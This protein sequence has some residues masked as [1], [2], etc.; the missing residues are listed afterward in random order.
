LEWKNST[1]GVS[2]HLTHGT[3]TRYVS[4]SS[5]TSRQRYMSVVIAVFV[6]SLEREMAG[7]RDMKKSPAVKS[8]PAFD[9]RGG[10]VKLR[11]L[12]ASR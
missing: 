5:I 11:I 2:L 8:E 10:K 6:S 9:L 3:Q 4:G 12:S 1:G 7:T